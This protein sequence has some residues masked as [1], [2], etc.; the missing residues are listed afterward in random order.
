MMPGI[1]NSVIEV[2]SFHLEAKGQY[3]GKSHARRGV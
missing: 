2:L 3:A 1:V